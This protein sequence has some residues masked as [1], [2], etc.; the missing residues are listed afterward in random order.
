MIALS[1]ASDEESMGHRLSKIYTRTGDDGTTGLAG[2]ARVPKDDPRV[3][4][5]GNVDE[6]SSAIALVLAEGDAAEDVRD[7]LIAIQH[8]LF[9]LGGELAMPEY[10]GITPADVERL[11]HALD[12][13]NAALPPLADF[14]LPGGGRSAAACFLARAVA[15]RAERSLWALARHADLNPDLPRYLNRLSDFLFVAAR[16]LT[17]DQGVPE[18]LWQKKSRR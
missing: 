10:R 17:R 8:D 13:L 4:A 16:R 2:G 3:E 15:R 5:L 14:I 9:D 1:F 6:T 12:A 18:T 11:E 7:A